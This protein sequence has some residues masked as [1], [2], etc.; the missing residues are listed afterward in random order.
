MF[1][2]GEKKKRMIGVALAMSFAAA[3]VAWVGWLVFWPAADRRMVIVPALQVARPL[4][5][6]GIQHKAVDLPVALLFDCYEN[7]LE[8]VPPRTDTSKRQW[9]WEA[10]PLPMDVAR[11]ELT[12]TG[13]TENDRKVLAWLEDW[14]EGGRK[15]YPTTTNQV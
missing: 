4:T 3:L 8:N 10:P 7:A 5:T 6:G 12:K 1:V 13:G 14:E 9:S 15:E 11:A 2:R